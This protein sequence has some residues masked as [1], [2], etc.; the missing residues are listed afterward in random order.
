MWSLLTQHTV[1]RCA[2][3]WVATMVPSVGLCFPSVH[4]CMTPFR[5]EAPSVDWRLSGPWRV[6]C[7]CQA[8]EFWSPIAPTNSSC[9]RKTM[10]GGPVHR[11]D[12][13]NSY[14]ALLDTGADSPTVTQGN[15]WTRHIVQKDST[16]LFKVVVSGTQWQDLGR[17]FCEKILSDEVPPHAAPHMGIVLGV[18]IEISTVRTPYEFDAEPDG[19]P[20]DNELEPGS[21]VIAE[22]T[23]CRTECPETLYFFENLAVPRYEDRFDTPLGYWSTDPDDW[24]SAEEVTDQH[25]MRQKRQIAVLAW[26]RYQSMMWGQRLGALRFL[27]EVRYVAQ[28]TSAC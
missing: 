6:A 17:W 9:V 26:T 3:T 24:P 8:R 15:G 14:G 7:L 4:I 1:H 27:F 2:H 12:E 13:E 18:R 22:T 20:R 23:E 11:H 16:L 28:S 10:F 21:D 5:Y 25:A 19:G